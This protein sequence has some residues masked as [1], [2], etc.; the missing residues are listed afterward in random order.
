MD[1]LLAAPPVHDNPVKIAA[2][3]T[4]INLDVKPQTAIMGSAA[5]PSPSAPA[6]QTGATRAKRHQIAVACGRC[7][8]RKSKCD[9]ARP[10][11]ASCKNRGAECYYDVEADATRAIAQKRRQEAMQRKLDQYQEVYQ[12]L[13]E[14]PHE[15]A[16]GILQRIRDGWDVLELHHFIKEGELLLQPPPHLPNMPD[17]RNPSAGSIDSDLGSAALEPEPP[18]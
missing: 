17:L 14:R 10:S 4:A 18:A 3:A 12:Y 11:C 6:Q 8:S 1:P 2:A 16:N 13:R 15:E 7:R 5:M 9:G